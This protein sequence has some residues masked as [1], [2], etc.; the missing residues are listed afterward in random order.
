MF[1][2]KRQVKVL[3]VNHISSHKPNYRKSPNFLKFGGSEN[4]YEKKMQKA[5]RWEPSPA[6]VKIEKQIINIIINLSP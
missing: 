1:L 4:C 2:N 5:K 3:G 6:T